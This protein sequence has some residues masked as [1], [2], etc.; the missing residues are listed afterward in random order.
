MSFSFTA[1]GTKDEVIAQLAQV[2]VYGNA[3]GESAR[4]M[5][6]NALGL[7]SV[8]PYTGYEYKYTVKASGHS[9][10]GSPLS[11]SLTVVGDYVP[12][13]NVTATATQA[14]VPFVP[15]ESPADPPAPA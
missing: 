2:D 6:V 4:L 12:L 15:V 10:G 9:G 1:V 3:I 8:Q 11:L 5:V 13:V 14:A 7:E